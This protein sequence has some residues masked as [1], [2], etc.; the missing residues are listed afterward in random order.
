MVRR[1]PPSS[2]R[3]RVPVS[4]STTPVDHEQTGLEHRVRH[5]VQQPRDQGD[6]GADG[7]RGADEAELADR[8]VGEQ[9]LEVVLPDGLDR[10]RAP[11]WRAER[12]TTTGPRVDLDGDRRGPGQQVDAGLD[13][14]GGVQVGATGVGATIAPRSQKP[15]GIRADLVPTRAGSSTI[16][17]AQR[18]GTMA[19][20]P[21]DE[22]R[23]ATWSRRRREQ[24]GGG[25]AARAHQPRS[26]R[27]PAGRGRP[28]TPSPADEQERDHAGEFPD[29]EE[30]RMS[31]ASTSVSMAAAKNVSRTGVFASRGRR[32]RTSRCRRGPGRRCRA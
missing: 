5:R 25:R 22:L 29:Q 6:L 28:L 31:S 23:S 13:H 21:A 11:W 16:A 8:R 15:N 30:D 19:T 20:G 9:R 2:R 32:R 17:G 26:R 1:R 7:Q 18:R 24:D 10:R 14:R 4:W 3:S 27:T 12:I